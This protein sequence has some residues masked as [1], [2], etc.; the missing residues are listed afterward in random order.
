M[1]HG[2][3]LEP[4]TYKK[5]PRVDAKVSFVWQRIT[6]EKPSRCIAMPLRF[7]LGLRRNYGN[8]TSVLA[9]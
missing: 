4:Y 5:V 9:D 8:I 1:G 3:P 2:S 7:C 6:Q